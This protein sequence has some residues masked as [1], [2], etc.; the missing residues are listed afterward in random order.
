MIWAEIRLKLV[1]GWICFDILISRGG[2]I[3][4]KKIMRMNLDG[5]SKKK[6]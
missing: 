1:G 3:D 6:N 4:I 2:G 5:R